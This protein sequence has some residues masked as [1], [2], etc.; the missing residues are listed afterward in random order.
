MTLDDLI[1]RWLKGESLASLRPE[2]EGD[3]EAAL[4]AEFAKMRRCVTQAIES[5]NN[6][7]C[8]LD[9]RFNETWEQPVPEDP[10][11]R[12]YITGKAY[13]LMLSSQTCGHVL[14]WLMRI[15]K[16]SP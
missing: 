10:W 15:G 9:A 1:T 6:A 11:R 5:T 7:A 16:G 12:G 8:E 13:G 14:N 4:R 2:C 3:P